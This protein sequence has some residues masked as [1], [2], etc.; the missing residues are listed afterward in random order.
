[1]NKRLVAPKQLTGRYKICT[2]MDGAE[3]RFETAIV[4][5]DTPYIKQRMQVVCVEN[6]EFDLIIGDVDG[7]R[8]KC[9][10]DS[11]WTL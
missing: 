7:A 8:C 2:L 9:N 10:P 5:I 4:D 6:P 1:M 11:N 3:K